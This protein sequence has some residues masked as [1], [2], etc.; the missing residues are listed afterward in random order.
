M[1]LNYEEEKAKLR[2][3]VGNSSPTIEEDINVLV[4]MLQEDKPLN[5]LYGFVEQK[6]APEHRK[7]VKDNIDEAWKTIQDHRNR[8]KME[9]EQV[10]LYSVFTIV[11]EMFDE[12]TA[13]NVIQRL[14]PLTIKTKPTHSKRV[15]MLIALSQKLNL[16]NKYKLK[17]T[18]EEIA[19]FIDEK[20]V[21]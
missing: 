18:V 19:K 4:E 11:G 21:N 15:D 1:A 20:G 14:L 17:Q 13:K 9:R 8:F 6:V 5:E 7:S 10:T 16:K 2:V 12:Q 3:I